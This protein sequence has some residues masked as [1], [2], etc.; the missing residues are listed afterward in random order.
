MVSMSQSSHCHQTSTLQLSTLPP[1]KPQ[2]GF[3]WWPRHCGRSNRPCKM[4]AGSQL[5][6]GEGAFA[7]MTGVRHYKLQLIKCTWKRWRQANLRVTDNSRKRQIQCANCGSSTIRAR[8]RHD[9]KST[10]DMMGQCTAAL[11]FIAYSGCE[12]DDKIAHLI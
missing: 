8:A 1:V 3:V 4:A 11:S 12:F 2:K 9:D 6:A 7:R 5:I 10:N